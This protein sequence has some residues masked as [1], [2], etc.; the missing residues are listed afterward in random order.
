MISP[1]NSFVGLTR[2]AAG[3][4]AELEG[5]LYPTGRR[6][7]LRVFPTDDL[8]GAA[9]ALLA[10]DRGRRTVYV[11]DDG[12]PGYGVLMA[13]G[14]ETAARRLGLR[15]AGRTT[16]NPRVASYDELADQVAA[17]G[18]AAVFVGGLLD[19]NAARVVRALRARIG[20]EI[21]VLGPDGLTPLPLL[22]EQA[23][24]AAHGTFVSL[25]GLV[26]EALPPA[27]AR[28]A[29][30]FARTQAGVAIE[31]S[32]VY[33]AQ[34]THVVLDAIARSD[35]SRADVLRELFRVRIHGGLLGDFGFDERGDITESPVTILRVERA[36]QSTRIMSVEGGVIERVSRPQ[37]SLVA[38]EP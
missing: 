17:S 5:Q 26:T 21:D 25:G 34:A 10:R 12:E 28:F 18:A 20:P 23:G 11:L 2:R 13:D 22:V 27:G 3:V 38:D 36:G 14:F 31:P 9:L 33:A 15:V 16:W 7:Y 30:R 35:G 37:A 4:P 6:N 8:Q 19:S 29:R 32:A 1:L 24:A